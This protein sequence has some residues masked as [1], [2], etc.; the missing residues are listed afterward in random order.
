MIDVTII[1]ASVKEVERLKAAKGCCI[2]IVMVRTI[3]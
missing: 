2:I 1:F 3:A